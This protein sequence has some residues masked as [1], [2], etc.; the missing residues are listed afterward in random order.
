MINSFKTSLQLTRGQCC[1]LLLA[2]LAARDLANDGGQKWERLH[3]EIKRQ[4]ADLDVQLY[5]VA[6]DLK[7]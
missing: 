2:C 5:Q 4:L 6:E 3:D 7:I 1:D